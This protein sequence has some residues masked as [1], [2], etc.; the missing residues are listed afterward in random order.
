MAALAWQ[1]IVDALAATQAA[2]DEAAAPTLASL[3]P[4]VADDADFAA[5][6][7]TLGFPI[8]DELKGVLRISN[9]GEEN[10]EGRYIEFPGA[11]F[12]R[13]LSLEEITSFHESLP[14]ICDACEEEWQTETHYGYNVPPN[15]KHGSGDFPILAHNDNW[16]PFAISGGGHSAP[17]LWLLDMAPGE[18]APPGRVIAFGGEG[19]SLGIW[20]ISLAELLEDIQRV[21]EARNAAAAAAVAPPAAAGAGETRHRKVLRDDGPRI[22]HTRLG[23]EM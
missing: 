12:E 16:L 8:P 10:K 9:G 19:D 2:N 21:L 17:M 7:A 11:P 15:Y 1:G 14:S 23:V 3:K 13:L 22:W 5:A 20:A 4:G 6:E 18:G